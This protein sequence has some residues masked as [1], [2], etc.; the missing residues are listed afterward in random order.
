MKKFL[1]ISVALILLVWFAGCQIPGG[2]E[3]FKK[4]GEAVQKIDKIQAQID[5]LQAQLN[6]L[7]DNFNTLADEFDQHMQ[8]Y[9]SKKATT[10]KPK[11]RPKKVP[12]KK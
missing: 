11:P 8:K 3:A 2:Q 12:R 7:T 4:L 6:E 1:I 5:S 9:H 10:P